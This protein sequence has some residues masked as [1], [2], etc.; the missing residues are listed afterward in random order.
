MD[1][2]KA[3]YPGNCIKCRRPLVDVAHWLYNPEGILFTD[4]RGP[5]CEACADEESKSDTEGEKR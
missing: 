5:Y 2:F 3:H 1:D 4:E